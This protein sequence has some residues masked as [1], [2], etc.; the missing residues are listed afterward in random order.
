MAWLHNAST[1]LQ[2]IFVGKELVLYKVGIG[3][4][5]T[6]T[7]YIYVCYIEIDAIVRALKMMYVSRFVVRQ[8]N[9]FLKKRRFNQ[10]SGGL[11]DQMFIIL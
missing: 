2:A 7:V 5:P 11:S 6:V 3:W 4:L 10:A 8:V 9:I 1:P